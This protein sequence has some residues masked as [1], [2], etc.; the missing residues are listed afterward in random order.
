[1]SK[2]NNKR[3]SNSNLGDVVVLQRTVQFNRDAIFDDCL[4]AVFIEDN[5][6]KQHEVSIEAPEKII[7]YIKINPTGIS[8]KNKRYRDKNIMTTIKGLSF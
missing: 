5:H 4:N 2:H 7:K 3:N 8:L 1:M 6:I